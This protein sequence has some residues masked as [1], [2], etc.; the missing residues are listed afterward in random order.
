MGEVE[1]FDLQP[2]DQVWCDQH[3]RKQLDDQECSAM[4]KDNLGR[5]EKW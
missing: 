1:G 4:G 2:A 3:H 5:E